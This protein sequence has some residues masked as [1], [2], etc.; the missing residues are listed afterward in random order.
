MTHPTPE[1]PVRR[2]PPFAAALL[3]LALAGSAP[4][5]ASAATV[6]PAEPLAAYVADYQ[7]AVT[8]LRAGDCATLARLN[9][10]ERF[11]AMAC[12]DETRSFYAEFQILGYS[13]YGTAAIIDRLG[14][15]LTN[16]RR[17]L[18]TDELAL[19]PGR[20]WHLVLGEVF[21]WGTGIRQL[22]TRPAP[23]VAF[24]ANRTLRLYLQSLRTRDC[25]L[26]F[27][28]GFTGNL[29]KPEACRRV[30]S[31]SSP[32]RTARLRRQLL[33]DPA[34]RPVS[35]GGTRDLQFYGLS[36]RPDRYWTLTVGRNVVPPG[37]LAGGI[38]LV[39]HSQA[40]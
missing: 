15:D 11:G 31:A 9:R 2:R 10:D 12:D 21:G 13:R 38:Y 35:L 30:F 34:A 20:R 8:A 1:V 26:Y 25:D 29:T 14:T 39:T 23:R 7:A 4:G 36:L 5:T 27:T 40:Q 17:A 6:T 3:V 28:T 18:F 19:G 32:T 16:R 37:P 33:A 22:G 24:L